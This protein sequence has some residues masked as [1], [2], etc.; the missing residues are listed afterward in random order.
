[1]SMYVKSVVCV[2]IYECIFLE[3][4]REDVRFSMKQTKDSHSRICTYRKERK[5]FFFF[6]SLS[7]SPFS[8]FLSFFLSPFSLCFDR[9]S[10]CVKFLRLFRHV[11]FGLCVSR[12]SRS[13][14]FAAV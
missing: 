5:V 3:L 2:S 6:L 10:L 13:Y 9:F 8:L 7:L 14:L 4:Q 11:G 12:W 1:M